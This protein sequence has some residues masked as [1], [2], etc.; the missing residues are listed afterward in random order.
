MVSQYYFLAS[1]LPPLAIGQK[2]DI[3][4]ETFLFLLETNL[5]PNDWAKATVIR[6]LYDL[7]NIRFFWKE[8]E[9]DPR[10]N[11][12]ELALEEALL[13]G[14]GFPDYV[15]DFLDKYTSKE[16][17]LR[18]FSALIA[19]YF[20]SE[21]AASQGFL[22]DYLEFERQLR[23]ILTGFRAKRMQRDLSKELQY[24]DPDDDI[25]A[26]LLASRDSKHFEPPEGYEQLKGYFHEGHEDPLALYQALFAYRFNWVEERLEVDLF[27]MD[28]ILGYMVQLIMVLKWMELDQD[29]GH[30]VIDMMIKE[31]L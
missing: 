12:D 26:Q 21:I 18:H 10:G 13:T 17:R 9:L 25:I 16:E 22:R 4:W 24:E 3:S 31:A 19:A 7:E 15:Y 30:Q 8:E 20:Q 11:F 6:R 1:V 14:D 28:R 29:R 2:A 27:S 5:K 23:L